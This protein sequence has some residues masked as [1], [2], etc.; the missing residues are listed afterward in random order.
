RE[1]DPGYQVTDEDTQ[2]VQRWSLRPDM[3]NG[4]GYFGIDPDSGYLK[5]LIDYDVDPPALM[6]PNQIFKVQVSDKGKLNATADV[7][8]TFVDCND[9][10]PVFVN[11]FYTYATTECT[12]KGTKLGTIQATDKDSA[13]EQNN[14]IYYQGSGGSVSVGT[15]GEV[16]VQNPEPAGTVI[17]FNAY[18]Y[19]SGQTPGPLKSINPTVI[20]VRFTPCPTTTTR[21]T[22]PSTKAPNTTH[23]T[24][25]S[26]TTKTLKKED[27]N[28]PW[29]ILASLLGALMLGLLTFML[30]RYGDLIVN[31][32]KGGCCSARNCWTRDKP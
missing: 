22:T 6:P 20:S 2:D 8:V 12:A 7:S 11:H 32:F 9:N 1:I 17:T 28:L 16:I 24:A 14:V 4:N 23:T 10:P 19:D 15:G 5:T 13:R 29:I 31:F 26:T 21:T 27:S 3:Y 18:A 30:W 25:A